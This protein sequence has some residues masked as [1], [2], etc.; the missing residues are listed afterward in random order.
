[1]SGMLAQSS[2]DARCTPSRAADRLRVASSQVTRAEK[3]P[4][5]SPPTV[6]SRGRSTMGA[7]WATGSFSCARTHLL[8]CASGSRI[9]ASAHWQSHMNRS[10]SPP[11]S[12]ASSLHHRAR[13]PRHYTLLGDNA[14]ACAISR[15][16][17]T[18][19]LHRQQAMAGKQTLEEAYGEPAN[20]LEIDVCNPQ[21]HGFGRGR[22]TD[23]EVHTRVSRALTHIISQSA[24]ARR[25]PTCLCSS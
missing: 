21:T 13:T 10:S 9:K 5:S 12:V 8:S 3:T 22:Y 6:R 16:I 18:D 24:H 23:Y 2:G 19:T 1:M 20:F 7:E 11:S 15:G 17:S 4:L 14:C 25:R